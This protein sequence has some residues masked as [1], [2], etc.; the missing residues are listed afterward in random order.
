M[1]PS[2]IGISLTIDLLN[3]FLKYPFLIPIKDDPSRI[4]PKWVSPPNAATTAASQDDGSTT[5]ATASQDAVSVEDDPSRIHPKWVSPPN[6][7]TTAASQD[8]GSTTTATASQALCLA[9]NKNSD[10][11][12]VVYI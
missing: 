6:A 9:P 3:L 1:F 2:P 8:A 4:H 10:R 7:A 5:T 11:Q 12:V